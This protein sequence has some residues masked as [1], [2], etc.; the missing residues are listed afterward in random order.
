[1]IISNVEKDGWWSGKISPL[2]T[3]TLCSS[4]EYLF[5]GGKKKEYSEREP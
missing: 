5:Q 1:M 3:T 2:G 4:V